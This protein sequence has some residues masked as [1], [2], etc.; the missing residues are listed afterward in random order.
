MA[1][2]RRNLSCNVG[3]INKSATL[4]QHKQQQEYGAARRSYK[5]L[6]RMAAAVSAEMAGGVTLR[7]LRRTV[8]R[9]NGAEASVAAQKPRN[10]RIKSKRLPQMALRH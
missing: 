10:R 9:L 7:K 2:A 3:E 5:R 8:M 6:A 4:R 1:A